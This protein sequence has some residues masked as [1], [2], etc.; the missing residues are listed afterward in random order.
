M[1]TGWRLRLS[2]FLSR[3]L[4]RKTATGPGAFVPSSSSKHQDVLGKAIF[5]E[6]VPGWRSRN[7][8]VAQE[9]EPR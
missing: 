4:R 1:R 6:E 7:G 5:S 2:S 8:K 9:N 3:S